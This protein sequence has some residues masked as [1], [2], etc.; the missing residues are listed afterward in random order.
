M[1][2]HTHIGASS[3]PQTERP[4]KKEQFETH[5]C[6]SVTVV[7]YPVRDEMQSVVQACLASHPLTLALLE[8]VT[9]SP[10]ASI[11]EELSAPLSEF[12]TWRLEHIIK[13]LNQTL[14]KTKGIAWCI[15]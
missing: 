8:S 9:N 6:V 13:I 11:L 14:P 3:Y 1:A 15:L 4:V 2:T 7:V 12:A 5:V 10:G